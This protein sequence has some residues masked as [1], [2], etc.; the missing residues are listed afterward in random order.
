[1]SLLEAEARNRGRG[2]IVNNHIWQSYK[3]KRLEEVV[4]HSMNL[5]KELGIAPT[6]LSMFGGNKNGW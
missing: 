3:N 4:P 2:D 1:M 5:V 6:I